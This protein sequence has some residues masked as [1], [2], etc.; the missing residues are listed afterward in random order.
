MPLKITQWPNDKATKYLGHQESLSNKISQLYAI[1]KTCDGHA[2]V[3]HCCHLNQLEVN[4][5]DQAIYCP[6]MGF[7]LSCSHFSEK[8]LHKA[9]TKA[10]GALIAKSGYNWNTS[11]VVLFG[12]HYIGGAGFFHIYNE[13]GYGQV[14]LFMK[15]WQ[16]PE[17]LQSN[18]LQVSLAWAQYNT[19]TRVSILEDTTTKLPH[20]E[21]VYLVS[22][23]HYLTSTGD[24]LNSKETLW[25]QSNEIR[26]SSLWQWC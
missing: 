19:G 13:Q 23:R 5:F 3:I 22:I 16:S 2:W 1:T 9:Q 6:S 18:L 17:S 14:K 20:L 7:C 21:S 26:M 10:H 12:P 24:R 25:F 4:T 11:L 15:M 8:E